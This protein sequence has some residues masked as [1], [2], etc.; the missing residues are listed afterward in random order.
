MV[1]VQWT[2]PDGP[3]VIIVNAH[4]LILSR[5][6]LIDLAAKASIAAE[7]LAYDERLPNRE[8]MS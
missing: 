8:Q 5:N 1:D 3:I 7:E 2:T 4:S 6:D